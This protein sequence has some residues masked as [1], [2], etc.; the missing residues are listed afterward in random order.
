MIGME[1]INNLVVGCLAF[2]AFLIVY[3]VVITRW[4]AKTKEIIYKSRL[5]D[6][7]DLKQPG[8]NYY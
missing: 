4:Y 3:A 1:T 6:L 2:I 8:N 7:E 5:E